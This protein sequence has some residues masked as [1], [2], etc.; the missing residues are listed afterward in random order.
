RE[1]QVPLRGKGVILVDGRFGGAWSVK[2]TFTVEADK[3]DYGRVGIVIEDT[4]EDSIDTAIKRVESSSTD[5]WK[6]VLLPPEVKH[7]TINDNDSNDF[8]D[9]E[10]RTSV[11]L[12]L[13]GEEKVVSKAVSDAIERFES[14]NGHTVGLLNHVAGTYR[15]YCNCAGKY[16][17][18][19]YVTL[20]VEHFLDF[21]S[22]N[23]AGLWHDVDGDEWNKQRCLRLS[24][25][26]TV[27]E[28]EIEYSISATGDDILVE[29]VHYA[30]TNYWDRDVEAGGN[31]FAW[32][33]KDLENTEGTLVMVGPLEN[34]GRAR[35]LASQINAKE[36]KVYEHADVTPKETTLVAEVS[37]SLSR[38]HSWI[39]QENVSEGNAYLILYRKQVNKMGF[40]GRRKVGLDTKKRKEGVEKK[41]MGVKG[42]ITL[43][44]LQRNELVTMSLGEA[45]EAGYTT[46]SHTWE[47]NLENV[48][49]HLGN[50]TEISSQR[51]IVFN[52][53]EKT[54]NML[55][56]SRSLGIRYTWMDY[57]CILQT[58]EGSTEDKERSIP[59]MGEYYRLSRTTFVYV[60]AVPYDLPREIFKRQY[61]VSQAVKNSKWRTRIWTFQEEAFSSDL[62]IVGKRHLIFDY[63]SDLQDTREGSSP[64]NFKSIMTMAR[65]RECT[66]P[67]D[68][69]YGTLSLLPYGKE[70]KI[71]Y[72]RG[73]SGCLVN[74]SLEAVKAGDYSFLI[75]G[76]KVLQGEEGKVVHYL[77]YP[78]DFSSVDNLSNKY[79]GK[80]A[81]ENSVDAYGL[82]LNHG[83]ENHTSVI[84]RG[85]RTSEMSRRM[86]TMFSTKAGK[87]T[88][89][90]KLGDFPSF[91][92]LYAGDPPAEEMNLF[93]SG[94]R[95]SMTTMISP[96]FHFLSS[97]V[98]SF[99]DRMKDAIATIIDVEGEKFDA[100]W[101]WWPF[102]EPSRIIEDDDH[103][104][105]CFT[106]DDANLT[107][108]VKLVQCDLYVHGTLPVYL[109]C[110]IDSDVCHR[111]GR[112]PHY[113]PN[114]LGPA[115]C[116]GMYHPH[117]YWTQR[118][119]VLG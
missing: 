50:E 117:R 62:V 76:G 7:V 86:Y 24:T 48:S 36:V 80:L 28:R 61:I 3:D 12:N 84:G 93:I 41:G 57:V 23:Y 104:Y 87:E 73:L 100:P 119:I 71:D 10:N 43:I 111:E 40:D 113:K 60:D 106:N 37:T 110:T 18:S 56:I 109:I 79:D 9:N 81:V 91:Y 78:R 115:F 69:V 68:Y 35:G 101:Y 64:Y 95:I 82:S 42:N 105:Y 2:R 96:D 75:N 20:I 98:D 59:M 6:I 39:L 63:Q 92:Q 74:L 55:S 54:K 22:H 45:V 103:A 107:G 94:N 49:W 88:G 118:T 58:G 116:T 65:T 33:R 32:V 85:E 4:Y 47:S 8:L 17:S 112:N 114:E 52:S 72:S 27:Y 29:G 14:D 97:S 30:A 51:L 31:A 53:V 26:W 77:S 34:L 19:T 90:I 108:A 46:W 15:S 16:L 83:V 89:D 66:L 5:S 11:V 13:Y 70:L 38:S 67:Q 25:Y 21:P 1:T 102:G 99:H 44:D